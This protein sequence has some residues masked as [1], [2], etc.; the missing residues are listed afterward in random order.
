MRVR[1]LL[2]AGIREA[3]GAG[4]LDLE[5]RRGETAGGV[6][7]SLVASHPR[8]D[9]LGASTRFARNGEIVTAAAPL[10]EGDELAVMPPFGG[11]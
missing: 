10:V 9:G 8:L 3:V 6:W 11:G 2:F 1:V 4:S 7:A 5:V